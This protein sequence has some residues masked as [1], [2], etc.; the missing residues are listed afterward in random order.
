MIAFGAVAPKAFRAYELES[1]LLGKKLNH[2][3]INQACDL[4]ENTIRP[5][6]DIR[7]SKEYRQQ[8]SKVLFKRALEQF[9]N[10]E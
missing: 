3:I 1:F 9:V 7:A 2:E 10:Q 6:T 8:L 5:I 4:V